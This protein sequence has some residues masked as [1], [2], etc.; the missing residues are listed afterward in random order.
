MVYQKGLCGGAVSGSD[1]FFRPWRGD[2][3]FANGAP[4]LILVGAL[5]T[6]IPRASGLEGVQRSV[7]GRSDVGGDALD[8]QHCPRA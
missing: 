1:V 6:E 2:S 3:G 4:A 5:M 8:V 7:S